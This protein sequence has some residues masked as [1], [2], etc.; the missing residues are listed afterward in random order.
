MDSP[1]IGNIAGLC[2]LGNE[3][4]DSVKAGDYQLLN[5]NNAPTVWTKT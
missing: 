5:K 4:W 3:P 1:W 2:G